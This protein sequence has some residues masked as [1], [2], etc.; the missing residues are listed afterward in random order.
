MGNKV[1]GQ[2][3]KHVIRKQSMQNFRKS[4]HFLQPDMQMCVCISWVEKCFF[5]GK[6]DA[7]CF[8]VTPVLRF[9]F[10]PYYQQ[11]FG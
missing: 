11:L 7:L 10:L 1:K 5:F 6:F 4:E 3:S 2:I 8:L 9:S